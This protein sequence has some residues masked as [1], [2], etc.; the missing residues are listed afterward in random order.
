M[1]TVGD[2]G[3]RPNS[4][5]VSLSS[6]YDRIVMKL[7]ELV[8]EAVKLTE[9]ERASLASQLLHSLESPVYDVSDDDVVRRREEAERDPRVLITFDEL[10]AGLRRRGSPIP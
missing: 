2:Q 8:A 3:V 9:E 4:G 5:G 6:G 7:E 1:R 10:V